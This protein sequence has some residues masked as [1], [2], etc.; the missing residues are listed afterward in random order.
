MTEIDILTSKARKHR[1]LSADYFLDKTAIPFQM[2]TFF[3]S[4]QTTR[5]E[6]IFKAIISSRSTVSFRTVFK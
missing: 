6:E 5:F 1:K 4:K 2:K 3:N